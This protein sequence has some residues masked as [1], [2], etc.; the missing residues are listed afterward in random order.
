V[1]APAPTGSRF[2]ANVLLNEIDLNEPIDLA[3]KF[4]YIGLRARRAH[5]V[6]GKGR[7]HLQ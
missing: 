6:R 5:P 1:K 2:R 4:F 7:A 3:M